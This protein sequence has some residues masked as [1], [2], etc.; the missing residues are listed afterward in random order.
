MDDNNEEVKDTTEDTPATTV[1][2]EKPVVED[3]FSPFDEQEEPEETKKVE[4]SEDDGM[5]DEDKKLID[6][7]IETKV[8]AYQQKI[9]RIEKMQAVDSFLADPENDLYKPFASKI[10]E[11]ALHPKSKGIAVSAIARM[12]VDPRKILEEGA[13]RA[14]AADIEARDSVSGG[15]DNRPSTEESKLP[16]AWKLS[17]DEFNKTISDAIVKR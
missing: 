6:E 8:G 17:K 10:R 12:A 5:I 15:A 7:R 1:P 14:Q 4:G 11:Y 3:T 16:N 9:D 2:E 13:K